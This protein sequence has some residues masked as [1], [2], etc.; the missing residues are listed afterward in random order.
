[1]NRGRLVVVIALALSLTAIP[2][3]AEDGPYALINANLFDGVNNA[4]GT[5]GT[6]GRTDLA[7]GRSTLIEKSL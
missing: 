2:A 4:I 1:M 5:K 3:F 7:E 6:K